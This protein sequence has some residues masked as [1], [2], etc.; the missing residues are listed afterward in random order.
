MAAVRFVDFLRRAL[1]RHGSRAEPRSG[2]PGRRQ[3][4]RGG[5]TYAAGIF[6]GVP[7]SDQLQQRRLRQRQGCGR[8]ALS[9]AVQERPDVAAAGPRASASA[10]AWAGRRAPRPSRAATRPMASRRS[11]STA[12]RWSATAR[13]GAFRPKPNTA[14]VLSAPSANTSFPPSMCGPRDRRRRPSWRTRPGSWPPAT[15]SRARIVLHRRRPPASVQLGERHLGRLG[16]RGAICGSQDRSQRV[17]AV[18]RSR[19]QCGRGDVDRTRTELVSQQD[20]AA[21]PSTIYQTRFANLVPLSS[22][23]ILRQ[24]EKAFITRFQNSF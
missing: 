6:N 3:T 10:P 24:D 12:A 13:S 20:R 16:S 14:T 19:G 18:R 23:Q 11:S 5:V 9:A 15:S 1:H 22:T 17:P 2:H 4:R 7:D 21:R 8:P